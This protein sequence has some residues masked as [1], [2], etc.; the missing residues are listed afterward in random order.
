MKSQKRIF[1]Y[2]RLLNDIKKHSHKNQTQISEELGCTIIHTSN[3]KNQKS[4]YSLEKIIKLMNSGEYCLDDYV[5]LEGRAAVSDRGFDNER[6]GRMPQEAVE[7]LQEFIQ[8]YIQISRKEKEKRKKKEYTNEELAKIAGAKIRRIRKAKGI[9]TDIM[10]KELG[11]REGSY[12]NME[13]GSTGT[14]LD[15]YAKIA[16]ILE[17]PVSEIFEEVLENKKP[18]IQYRMKR[19]FEGLSEE[20]AEMYQNMMEELLEIIRKYSN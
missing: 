2:V 11:M 15:N 16:N 6:F 5:E 17:V 3:V 12:R 14:T 7:A 9:G 13:N 1:N 20:E 10:A 19:M 18:V 8:D 4:N